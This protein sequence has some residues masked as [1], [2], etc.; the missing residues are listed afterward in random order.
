M[1]TI[2]RGGLIGA[3]IALVLNLALF[4]VMSA[5]DVTLN[6]VNDPPYPVVTVLP[7][8]VLTLLAAIGATAILWLL[9]RFT[10]RPILIFLWV[11]LVVGL[12]SFIPSF[13]KTA[14]RPAFIGLGLLHVG[15]AIGIIW[16]ILFSS[17]SGVQDR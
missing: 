14:T 8:V 4:Y 16:G 2:I 11:A 3:V 12:L 1:N 10:N 15:A 9:D 6:L 13:L 17:Q 7:V 5:L